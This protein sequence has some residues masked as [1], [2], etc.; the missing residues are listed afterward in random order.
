[1]SWK[2]HD[3]YRWL[4]Y[5]GAMLLTVGGA[6]AFAAD[7]ETREFA[8]LVDGK[9]AG[10]ANMTIRRQDDGVTVV[11][12]ATKVE[13]RVLIKKYVYTCENREVWK[14][15]RLQEMASRCNDDGKQF[16]VSA[17]A[18]ADGVHVRVNGRERTA[19]PEV[20]LSSYWTLP[21]AKL[22]E[23]VVPVIDADN[24]RD[25]QVRIQHVGAERI[26]VAGEARA[27]HHYRLTGTV[28]VDLWYDD[29][30]RLVRQSWIE[31]G[32]PTVLQLARVRR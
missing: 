22:R 4:V 1:M 27:V 6:S 25:L 21:D 26:T 18:Q 12:S 11:S 13:V 2:F 17:V 14:G 23:G 5:A 28:R 3:A 9:Q 8:V 24:G 29:A 10:S 31:D 19:K 15:G 16:Q 7:S 32:H 20:W 30:E